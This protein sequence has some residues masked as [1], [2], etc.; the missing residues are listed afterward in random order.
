MV[1]W[2]AYDTKNFVAIAEGLAGEQKALEEVRRNLRERIKASPLCNLVEFA[3]RMETA[4]RQ[5][6]EAHAH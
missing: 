5:A 4:L 2:I 6:Y 3:K 1:D